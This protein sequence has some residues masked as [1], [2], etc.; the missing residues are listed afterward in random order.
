MRHPRGRPRRRAGRLGLV[1]GLPAGGQRGPQPALGPQ[2]LAQGVA[3]AQG[4]V[5][6]P[7]GPPVGGDLGQRG[8]GVGD[9]TLQQHCHGQVPADEIAQEP[10]VLGDLGQGSPGELDG[11]VGVAMLAGELGPQ[12]R[13]HGGDVGV[14]VGVRVGGSLPWVAG[15]GVF[16]VG[17][18]GLD[19]V[20]A[21]ADERP[22]GPGQAQPRPGT[23]Q[24][25][26]QRRQPA[27]DRGAL[28]ALEALLG[29]LLDQPGRPVGLPGGQG[30]VHRLIDQPVVLQPGDRVPMQR[31]HAVGL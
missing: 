29:V 31:R 20:D 5:R 15:G 23:E 18:Q 9:P 24:P 21:T 19:L 25:V 12:D 14:P 17:E 26:G 3:G 22:D 30:V 1:E 8:F 4:V 16:G 27:V 28:A 13:Q 7:G 11:V 10:V 2:G 6:L